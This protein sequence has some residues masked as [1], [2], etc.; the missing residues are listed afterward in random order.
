MLCTL[1]TTLFEWQI[2]KYGS[3]SKWKS[4]FKIVNGDSQY[5]FYWGKCQTNSVEGKDSIS[6][7]RRRHTWSR[8]FISV[9]KANFAKMNLR[10]NIVLYVLIRVCPSWLFWHIFSVN[11]IRPSWHVSW[12]LFMQCLHACYCAWRITE[13]FFL[14]DYN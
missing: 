5:T 9:L 6:K 4:Q 10:G 8:P 3:R 7:S 14:N 11:P 12:T 2:L 1:V 13:T